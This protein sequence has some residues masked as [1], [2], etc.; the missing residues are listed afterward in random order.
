MKTIQIAALAGLSLLVGFAA[1]TGGYAALRL[2]QS[3]RLAQGQ[4]PFDRLARPEGARLLI[5]G[6]SMAEGRGASAPDYSLAGLLSRANP[7]LTVV[8]RGCAGARFADFIDQLDGDERFDAVLVQGGAND[9]LR[10]TPAA[11]L[12]DSVRQVA[13]RART[14]AGLV[15]FMPPGNVG[16]AAFFHPPWSWWMSRRSRR[17]H[18]IVADEAQANGALY[19]SLFQEREDDPFARHPR[20]LYARDGLHP[21]DAGYELWQRELET[22]VQL[23]AKLRR[24]GRG[25]AARG[26][27]F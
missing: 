17:L 1:G 16:N 21:N 27:I 25:T 3:A 24:I 4:H 11:A 10:L 15:V 6:D 5:I 26:G 20:R 18:A 19:V 14:Y 9:V 13:Q 23:S 12:R 7:S 8:N 2:R 22:Q